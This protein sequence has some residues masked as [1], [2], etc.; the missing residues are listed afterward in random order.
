M[1]HPLLKR[2][3]LAV[4][5]LSFDFPPHR[6]LSV[7][8]TSSERRTSPLP[9]GKTANFGSRDQLEVSLLHLTP[10]NM[11]IFT[12]GVNF[13]PN[14]L[15][16]KLYFLHQLGGQKL[17]L[18]HEEPTPSKNKFVVSTFPTFCLLH[19]ASFVPTCCQSRYTQQK[20]PNVFTPSPCPT[21]SRLIPTC[22]TLTFCPPTRLTSQVSSDKS[23]KVLVSTPL[24]SGKKKKEKIPHID[25]NKC[26]YT[27]TFFDKNA[28]FWGSYDGKQR[29]EFAV[30][31]RLRAF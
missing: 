12:V 29:A 20:N 5:R 1:F 2:Q 22:G 15:K 3:Q 16:R 9:R 8:N 10:Q 19:N 17:H 13:P 4:D 30:S 11:V 27:F 21:L 7:I 28:F 6:H 26:R 14:S 24:N 25:Q 18:P 31:W 23:G